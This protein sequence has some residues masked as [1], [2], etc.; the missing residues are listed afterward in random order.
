[1]D[2]DEFD[3]ISASASA[4]LMDMKVDLSQCSK[5]AIFF[6]TSHEKGDSNE[7]CLE[8]FDNL[9]LKNAKTQIQKKK[10]SIS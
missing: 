7:E 10:C 6:Q 1:M 8:S 3:K 2:V 9:K 4:S 5:F